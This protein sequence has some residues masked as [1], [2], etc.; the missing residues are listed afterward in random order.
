QVAVT[1]PDRFQ[2]PQSE[3]ARF[4]SP[5][6]RNH[7]NEEAFKE[8]NGF[9]YYQHLRK[10]GGTGFCEMAGSR[11]MEH[12]EVPR[13][14]CMPD[15]RGGMATPPWSNGGYLLEQMK[16]H[17]YRITANE[18]DAFPSEHLN[19]PGAVFGTTFRY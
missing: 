7:E 17:S 2:C 14:H 15:N 18:W 8:G 3:A 10:A 4:S 6:V 1:S 19:L 11:N 16:A 5:D 13:Y 12:S 9:I